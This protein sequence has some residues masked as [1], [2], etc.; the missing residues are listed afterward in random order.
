MQEL[1]TDFWADP[2]DGPTHPAALKRTFGRP[3]SE[4]KIKF[5]RD[6]AAWCPYC[7]KVCVCMCVCVC[8]YTCVCVCVCVCVHVCMCARLVAQ[9][10]RSRLSF[11]GTTRHGT[12]TARRCVCVC[13]CMRVYVC[14]RVCMCVHVFVC[15]CVC[16]CVCV[17]VCACMCTCVCVCVCACACVC[18]CVC[19]VHATSPCIRVF[20]I[21][22]TWH[23]H[24]VTP[25]LRPLPCTPPPYMFVGVAAARGEAHPVHHREGRKACPR[26]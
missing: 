17:R 24:V 15:V 19:F 26:V 23:A 2:N 25:A 10:R 11:T 16:V 14:V 6:H 21:D 22:L 4:I 7:Q 20:A 9:I 18:V 5:Y 8:A 13:V 1:G 12:L 3:E